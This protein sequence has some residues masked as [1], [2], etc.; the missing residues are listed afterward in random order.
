MT[1]ESN[2]KTKRDILNEKIKPLGNEC[3]TCKQYKNNKR[4]KYLH[5][6]GISCNYVSD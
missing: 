3:L 6:D 4:C 5:D 1:N 2:R